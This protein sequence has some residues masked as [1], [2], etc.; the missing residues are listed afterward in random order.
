MRRRVAA[1]VLVLVVVAGLIWALVSLGG[2]DD[3]VANTASTGT[4]SGA[5]ESAEKPV[6]PA[7]AS[8]AEQAPGQETEPSI[9]PRSSAKPAPG[10]QNG[11][12]PAAPGDPGADAKETPSPYAEAE[13]NGQ[14][15]NAA[16]EPGAQAAAE[17][18]QT[19]ELADL[20]ITAS[21]DNSNYVEGAL[22][23]FFMTVENPTAADCEI[24]LDD[25]SL[26]F[27]VYD[28]S[29]N[30]RVWSDT[31]CYPSVETGMQTFPAGEKRIFEAEWSRL[32]SAPGQCNDRTPAESG[33]YFLHAVIGDNPS[34]ALTFNLV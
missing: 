25:S 5:S 26:R 12:A 15:D 4:G 24:N 33:A 7:S 3:D 17:K 8:S 30:A 23:R 10:E 20:K 14:G 16:A 28:L 18:K 34:P 13:G 6:D 21:S 31:D 27:E 29:N 9:A 1:L 22:P 11:A 2:G 32:Q 19:C